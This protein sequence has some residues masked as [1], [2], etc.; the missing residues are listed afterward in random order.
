LVYSAMLVVVVS[1]LY[2][3][4]ALLTAILPWQLVYLL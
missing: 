1:R 3:W 2:S 4:P